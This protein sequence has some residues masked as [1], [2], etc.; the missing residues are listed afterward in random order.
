MSRKE[1]PRMRAW[2]LKNGVR[3]HIEGGVWDGY[4]IEYPNGQVADTGDA[5]QTQMRKM[6]EEGHWGEVKL[7]Q[8]PRPTKLW[9]AS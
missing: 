1:R 8:W 6:V 9:F 5:L 3:P 4:Q 7:R 2:I